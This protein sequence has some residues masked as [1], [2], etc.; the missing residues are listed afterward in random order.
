[1]KKGLGQTTVI[2]TVLCVLLNALTVMVGWQEGVKDI[3][4]MKKTQ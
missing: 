3:R 2:G 1:M 4:R